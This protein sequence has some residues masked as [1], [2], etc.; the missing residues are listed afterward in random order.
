MQLKNKP[1]CANFRYH[2]MAIIKSGWKRVFWSETVV[3]RYP[4]APN[5][6]AKLVHDSIIIT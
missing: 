2:R 5:L 3:N 1:I 6:F 4:I